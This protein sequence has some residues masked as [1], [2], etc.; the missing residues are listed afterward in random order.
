M[1]VVEWGV[2]STDVDLIYKYQTRR[3]QHRTTWYE[4]P[5]RYNHISRVQTASWMA[6]SLVGSNKDSV[7]GE[8]LKVLRCMKHLLCVLLENEFST[9]NDTTRRVSPVVVWSSPILSRENQA[10]FWL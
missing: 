1:Q 2:V 10:L 6:G 9:C 4:T 7:G 8:V 5:E 3:E